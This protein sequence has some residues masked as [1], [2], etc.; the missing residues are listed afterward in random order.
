MTFPALRQYV[1]KTVNRGVSNAGK[2]AA[3]KFT[4]RRAEFTLQNIAV[5]TQE[6][7]VSWAVPIPSDYAVQVVP[8]TAAAF[9]GLLFATPKAGTKTP[10]GCTVIVANRAL[11][12]IGV[13]TFDVL[14]TPL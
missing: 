11:V 5:G 7:E 14:A 13:A 9:V 3:L 10:T 4:P 8:T 1:V 12:S 2:D 6:V